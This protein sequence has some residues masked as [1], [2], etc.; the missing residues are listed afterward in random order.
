M[1]FQSVE[2]YFQYM[3]WELTGAQRERLSPD[4]LRTKD[5][6]QATILQRSKDQGERCRSL[7]NKRVFGFRFDWEVVKVSEG[8]RGCAWVGGSGCGCALVFV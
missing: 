1:E 8:Q 5:E 3:K 7:G 4:Q 6:H 2:Q